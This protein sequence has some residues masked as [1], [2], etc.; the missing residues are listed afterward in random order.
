M[1]AEQLLFSSKSHRDSPQAGPLTLVRPYVMT[2]E[3]FRTRLQWWMIMV[4]KA[5]GV[6]TDAERVGETSWFFV[7]FCCRG[8]EVLPCIREDQCNKRK[9]SNA[10]KVISLNQR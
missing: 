3:Q 5:S 9:I 8:G 10:N 6:A 1:A 2:S 4:S 7:L